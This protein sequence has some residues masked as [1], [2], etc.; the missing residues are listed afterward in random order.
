MIKTDPMK[1]FL[2]PTDF[3]ETSRNALLYA[4]E[5]AAELEA[6]SI[7]V[8]HVFLPETAGEADFI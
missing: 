8:V 1:K 3:S 2:V 5:L 4:I 7:D 6:K